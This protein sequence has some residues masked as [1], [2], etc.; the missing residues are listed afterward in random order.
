MMK[1]WPDVYKQLLNTIKEKKPMNLLTLERSQ[2]LP[3][4]VY[5]YINFM[6]KRQQKK[7]TIP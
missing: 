2:L 5:Y 7:F 1:D 6:T 4:D 3:S